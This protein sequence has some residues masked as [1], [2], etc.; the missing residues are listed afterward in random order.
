M[1]NPN[2]NAFKP[3]KPTKIFKID[4][5]IGKGGRLFSQLYRVLHM[6][7]V[8]IKLSYTPCI[9]VHADISQ[10]AAAGR[11]FLPT[12]HP[13]SPHPHPRS[14]KLVPRSAAPH[15]LSHT[16]QIMLFDFYNAEKIYI[17]LPSLP[18]PPPP[19]TA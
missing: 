9:L 15:S 19:A 10:F 1:K 5:T 8:L 4:H 6:C 18:S 11:V 16:L 3:L 12:R 17:I 14:T 7:E 2:F 13:V